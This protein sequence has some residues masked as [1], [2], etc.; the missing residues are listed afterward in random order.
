MEANYPNLSHDD[1]KECHE[2]FRV[3]TE[4]KRS[5][6]PLPSLPPPPLPAHVT[7]AEVEV[8]LRALGFPLS[9]AEVGAR[10][11]MST[12][13]GGRG[14][15][16]RHGFVRLVSACVHS[17]QDAL[18]ACFRAFDRDGDGLLSRSDLI[19]VL[20]ALGESMTVEELSRLVGVMV[21]GGGQAD[22]D[23]MISLDQFLAYFQGTNIS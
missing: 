19:G 6:S 1:I 20:G 13:D 23:Q 22:P 18:A 3:Y 14:T 15:L 2:V 17:P 10:I 12:L 4:G 21:R 9:S 7:V 5:A 11:G 8:M 16:D